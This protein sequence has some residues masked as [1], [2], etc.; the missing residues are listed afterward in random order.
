MK[1]ILKEKKLL[2]GIFTGI[3]WIVTFILWLVGV[4][5]SPITGWVFM[6]LMIFFWL[7]AIFI[8]FIM[9]KE[10]KSWRIHEKPKYYEYYPIGAIFLMLSP[11]IGAM[12]LMYIFFSYTKNE[13]D[14]YDWE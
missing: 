13:D 1:K 12:I 4:G 6:G 14:L 5:V 7:V 9:W 11:I 8:G 2:I 3:G 10:Y